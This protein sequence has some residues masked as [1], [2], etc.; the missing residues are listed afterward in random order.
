MDSQI[1]SNA[2]LGTARQPF[3]TPAGE[4]EL[5]DLMGQLSG[6]NPEAALLGAAAAGFLFER[7]GAS[8][9]VVTG[10]LTD[11]A[12]PETRWRC[13]PRSVQHLNRLVKDKHHEILQEW[14]TALAQAGKRLP[15][16]K[17]PEMLDHLQSLPNLDPAILRVV[18]ERGRWLAAQNP[19]WTLFAEPD[20][21]TLRETWETGNKESRVGVLKLL[22]E[23]DTDQ[24]RTLLQETWGSE[25]ADG[26]K[27]LLVVFK[28]NLSM[29]DEPFLEERLDDRSK[30]VRRVAAD[31]LARLP[32][33]AFVGRM[34]A[35]ADQAIRYDPPKK[36]F[37]NISK[38][39]A[40]PAFQVTPF[41]S[42]DPAMLRDGIE[43]KSDR[44]ALGD[45][46]FILSQVVA[47]LPPNYWTHKWQTAPVT[48]I[49]EA[50]E[51]EYA[52]ALLVGWRSAVH[53]YGAGDW[54]Q[55]F[56]Q[57]YLEA[58]DRNKAPVYL[59]PVAEGLSY[60]SFERLVHQ[61]LAVEREPLYD[62]HPAFN[63][64]LGY[65]ENTGYW[66][67]ELVLALINS[68]KRRIAAKD[69]YQW[70]IQSE[71]LKVIAAHVPPG[72]ADQLAT[73]WPEDSPFWPNWARPVRE[74]LALLELRKEMLKE[75]YS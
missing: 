56:S 63:L 18:G 40:P 75:I 7:A 33:S 42:A 62:R 20:G 74:F 69:P 68:L 65:K 24:A 57:N 15:E 31:L 36:S 43:P 45:K 25:G 39:T 28:Q 30:E 26:R 52:E 44:R 19:A 22:R 37:L 6:E 12:A 27:A 3:Q 14:L 4:A 48:L 55:A 49:K 29:A 58:K 54:S 35:R 32:G 50:A 8:L 47:N 70:R 16:E 34:M 59:D 46:A 53:R 21:E 51:S 41:E 11:P 23:R 67:P 66:R 9:P 2:L 5:G 38:K 64:V 17:L 61:A 1:L 71:G 13:S 72:M 10:P 73:G 60:E